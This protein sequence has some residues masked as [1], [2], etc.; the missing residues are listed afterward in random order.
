MKENYELPELT[1]T[2]EN[3]QLITDLLSKNNQIKTEILSSNSKLYATFTIDQVIYDKGTVVFNLSSKPGEEY[4]FIIENYPILEFQSVLSLLSP[5]LPRVQFLS[6]NPKYLTQLLVEDLLKHLRKSEKILTVRD[7]LTNIE[8]CSDW[9]LAFK[10][11]IPENL[12]ISVFPFR[13]SLYVTVYQ[14]SKTEL[15]LRIMHSSASPFN[16]SSHSIVEINGF[17]YQIEHSLVASQSQQFLVRVLR[18][19]KNA[20][21]DLETLNSLML[22]INN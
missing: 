10:K 4:E 11:P 9:N 12:F 21:E 13:D 16:I 17:R 20:I 22:Q 18:S 7:V 3:I 8:I 2:A 1:R 14:V 5:L 6:K 15:P 19:L